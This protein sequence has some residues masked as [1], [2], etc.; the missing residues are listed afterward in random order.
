M[1]KRNETPATPVRSSRLI[2][3]GGA[4]ART[5]AG[6]GD[7]AIEEQPFVLYDPN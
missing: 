4:K 5:N 2:L 1:S 3:A 7:K 6:G